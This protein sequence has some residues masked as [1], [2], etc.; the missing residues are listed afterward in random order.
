MP[1]VMRA[2]VPKWGRPQEG[3][4][5]QDTTGVGKMRQADDWLALAARKAPMALKH[6][7]WSPFRRTSPLTIRMLN[8]RRSK[9]HAFYSAV[10]CLQR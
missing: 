3:E 10:S 5:E 2:M 6:P 4:R 7:I 9:A 1:L 8:R